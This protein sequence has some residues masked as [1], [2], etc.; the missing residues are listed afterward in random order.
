MSPG[1]Y[2][3]DLIIKAVF[4]VIKYCIIFTGL[5]I[6]IAVAVIDIISDSTINFHFTIYVASFI[7]ALYIFAKNLYHFFKFK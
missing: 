1:E 6:P 7:A 5:T 2:L 3:S 4:G